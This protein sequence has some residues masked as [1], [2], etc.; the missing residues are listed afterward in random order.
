MKSNARSVFGGSYTARLVLFGSGLIAVAI[1]VAILFAP[2]AFY[3]DYGIDVTG[4]ATLA[5]ELKA[6]AG[7]LLVAGL[8]IFAGAFRWK[9]AVVSLTTAAVV[10]LSY[11]LSRVTSIAIDGVPHSGMVNAAGVELVI[12]AICLLTLL[13][14]RQINTN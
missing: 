1:A 13:Q 8:V 5:N 9:L 12:G 2:A 14:V 6:P 11:G 3:A 4:D 10:Y 7:A